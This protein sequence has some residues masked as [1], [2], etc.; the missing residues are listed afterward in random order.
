MFT[1]DGGPEDQKLIIDDDNQTDTSSNKEI[2][3]VH[4]CAQG[5]HY[6]WVKDGF[7]D[8][9]CNVAACRYDGGDCK[10][11]KDDAALEKFRQVHERRMMAEMR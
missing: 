11:A 10:F 2:L 8:E 1:Q 5:C 6:L 4:E 9:T 3:Q 7:C